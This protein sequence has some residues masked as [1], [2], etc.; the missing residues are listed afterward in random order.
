MSSASYEHFNA[1]QLLWS[2]TLV[3][4][5]GE[6]PKYSQNKVYFYEDIIRRE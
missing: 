3:Y 4:N 6:T 1:T 5:V 2:S